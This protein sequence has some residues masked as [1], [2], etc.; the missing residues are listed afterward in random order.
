MSVAHLHFS[1]LN[2]HTKQ[3]QTKP[4]QT[5][6]KQKKGEKIH[7]RTTKQFSKSSIEIEN[8]VVILFIL[9]FISDFFLKC[10]FSDSYEA[11]NPVIIMPV[12]LLKAKFILTSQANRSIKK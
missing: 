9:V 2:K 12:G 7:K 4:N 6:T 1:R 10:C 3:E 5:K 8:P 11:V